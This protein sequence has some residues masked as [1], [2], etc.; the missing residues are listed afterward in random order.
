MGELLPGDPPRIE[1]RDEHLALIETIATKEFEGFEAR[2]LTGHPQLWEIDQNVMRAELRL[3]YDEEVIDAVARPS[4]AAAFEVTYGMPLDHGAPS[5]SRADPVPLRVGDRVLQLSGKIDR[6]QW[7]DGAPDFIVIDYKTGRQKDK[8]TA[9]F[10]GGNALQLPLYLHGAAH[11]LGRN[12]EDGT[13]EYF[14][15]SRRGAFA[16]HVMTGEKLAASA[17]EFEQVL[18]AF[19]DAMFGGLYPARPEEWTCRYCEFKGLCPHPIEHADRMKTK[20]EDPRL[21]DLVAAWEVK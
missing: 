8:K 11:L 15:V 16:R 3:W 13:A 1:R 4:D 5:M 2:G 19:A 17:G 18:A 14:Y 10:D 9:V 12:P 7:R 20:I 21:A 6:L